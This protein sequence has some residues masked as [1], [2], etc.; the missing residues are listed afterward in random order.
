MNAAVQPPAGGGVMRRHGAVSDRGQAQTG[1]H[2]RLEQAVESAD[3]QRDETGKRDQC[4]ELL[5]EPDLVVGRPRRAALQRLGEPVEA[6]ADRLMRDVLGRVRY[7]GRVQH[8]GGAGRRVAID[9]ARL[10]RPLRAE[11]RPQLGALGD[12]AGE[13]DAPHQGGEFL[14]LGKHQSGVARPAG[15]AVGCEWLTGRG[16]LQHHRLVVIRHRGGCGQHR[17]AAHRVTLEADIGLVDDVEAA[18]IGEAVRAAKAVGKGGRVTIAM[19]GLVQRQHDIAAAGEFDG[20]AVLGLA[21][22]DVAV[23]GEDARCRGLR[24]GIRGDVEQGTHGVALGA[25]EPDILDPDAACGLRQM[26]DEA[27]HHDQDRS[28]NCQRPS[29]AHH[30][31]PLNCFFSSA[32]SASL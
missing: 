20:E 22:I 11:H 29:T 24:G 16:A 14:V 10:D 30:V 18:E 7:R 32:L 1:E 8:P 25:L 21:R 9:L 31:P 3:Q 28:Q 12:I 13:I 27:A 5:A 2:L 4:A 17:P 6:V 26:G 19:A 23:D 15:G